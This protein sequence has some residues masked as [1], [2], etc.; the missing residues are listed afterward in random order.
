MYVLRLDGPE[1]L[2]KVGMSR[3]PL[4]RWSSFHPRWFEAFDLD[5]SLLVETETRKDA[6]ALET[7]LHRALRAHACPLPMTVREQAGGGTEWY[8]GADA[9]VAAFV[10]ALP[11]QGYA[12]PRAA[13]AWL[14]AAMRQRQDTIVGLVH[15][16][17]SQHCAGWLAPAQ[18]QALQD[19]LDAHRALDPGIA[20][21]WPLDLL[22]DMGIR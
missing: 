10:E 6:Q 16:A 17:H 19:L 14:A 22:D 13:R 7:Q 9:A 1:D 4:A 2:L 21:A 8:R 3:D 12:V 15:D 20:S 11:G 5:R 18:R